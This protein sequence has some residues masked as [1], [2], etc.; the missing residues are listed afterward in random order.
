MGVV[1][2]C[3][4][5]GYETDPHDQGSGGAVSVLTDPE[6][7]VVLLRCQN[8]ELQ[9]IAAVMGYFDRT[10]DE[11]THRWR[12]IG[13]SLAL[14]PEIQR[15]L[16]DAPRSARDHLRQGL[17]LEEVVLGRVDPALYSAE[18]RRNLRLHLA[19]L[20]DER[21]AEI[22]GW[23][24]AANVAGSVLRVVYAE[25]E[26]EWASLREALRE[27][28]VCEADVIED[29]L[30]VDHLVGRVTD[31]DGRP[32]SHPPRGLEGIAR[33]QAVA[34]VRR[35]YFKAVQRLGRGSGYRGS[36]PVATG[37][38]PASGPTTRPTADNTQK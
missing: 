20:G 13:P 36:T 1:G 5:L 15:H 11:V 16:F 38:N 32:R 3:E 37:P 33:T 34:A 9:E 10:Y 21:I 19:G 31:E 29:E 30:A 4:D 18:D 2:Y 28:L 22:T 6:R 27:A 35:V 12:R 25:V 17:T 14:I 26:A 7:Q 24:R 8:R 23:T